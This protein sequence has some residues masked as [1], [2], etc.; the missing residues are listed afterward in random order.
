M[1][2]PGGKDAGHGYG[3]YHVTASMTGSAPGSAIVFWPADDKWPGQ[4]FDMGE[5]AAD[6]SGRRYSTVHWNEGGHDAGDYFISDIKDGEKHD[7][8]MKW[9]PGQITFTM[10]GHVIG[11]E[12]GH[13]PADFAHGGM[14]DTIGF[15]NN[16]DATS[17]TVYDVSFTEL[18]GS[19]PAPAPQPAP[20]V[21]T[22]AV[23]AAPAPTPVADTATADVTHANDAPAT[24]DAAPVE[25]TPAAVDAAPVVEAAPAAVDAA[26]VAETHVDVP[27]APAEGTLEY[28]A[29]AL[30]QVDDYLAH[31]FPAWDAL[32][33]IVTANYAETG[34]WY[35][36]LDL[37]GANIPHLESPPDA[38]DWN[39]LADAVTANHDAQ[40]QWF[41]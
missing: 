16:N 15:M 23:D 37:S 36:G 27:A 22:K 13:V 5:A 30:A 35:P 14:N 24:V 6:G 11:T 31:A 20:V 25:V 10:D 21:E 38:V 39:A 9:E 40:G 32:A 26:P 29:Q 17:I 7:Y 4:E 28:T 8:G 19:T 1:E 41:V 2:F 12:T 33:A 3:E 18:G 34:S